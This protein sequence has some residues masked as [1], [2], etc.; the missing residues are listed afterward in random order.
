M[1]KIIIEM[2]EVTEHY[3]T[4]EQMDFLAGD[5]QAC[6]RFVFEAVEGRFQRKYNCKFFRNLFIV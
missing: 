2:S 1:Q 3:F 6:M 4:Q 5:L